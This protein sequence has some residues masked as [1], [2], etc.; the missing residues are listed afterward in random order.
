VPVYGKGAAVSC[1]AMSILD[2]GLGPTE[3]NCRRFNWPLAVY[4]RARALGSRLNH[5]CQMMMTPI[6]AAAAKLEASSSQR[7]PTR[8]KSLSRQN[9]RSS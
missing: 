5:I 4:Y 7:I 8:R 1:G 3:L 9:M 6:A 2:A